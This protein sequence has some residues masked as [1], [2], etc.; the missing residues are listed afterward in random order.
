MNP[1]KKVQL[2]QGLVVGLVLVLGVILVKGP[3]KHMGKSPSEAG[4]GSKPLE[5][6]AQKYTPRDE[7]DPRVMPPAPAPEE[8][9]AVPPIAYTAHEVRDPFKSLLPAAA[10]SRVESRGPVVGSRSEAPSAPPDLLVQGL[11]WGGDQP[12]AIIRGNVYGVGEL[13]EGMKIVAIDQRGVTIEFQGSSIAYP[14]TTS[15]PTTS[16]GTSPM[17]PP[18]PHGGTWR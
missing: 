18:L 11:V 15:T 8:V 5:V 16:R 12:K 3:L 6:L 9:V 1:V 13:V 4:R 2:E 7:V 14:V 17:R 10:S